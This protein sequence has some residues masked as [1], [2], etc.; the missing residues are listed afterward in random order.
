MTREQ[1]E[2]LSNLI[3]YFDENFFQDS[4]KKDTDTVCDAVPVSLLCYLLLSAK[5]S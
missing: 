1:K 4:K 5:H 3:V 2:K